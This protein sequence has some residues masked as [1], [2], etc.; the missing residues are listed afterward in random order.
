MLSG[1]VQ[2]M[3]S[4]SDIIIN[5]GS[6][7]YADE[8]ERINKLLKEQ[9]TI[10]A[11]SARKGGGQE[12]REKE[13]A[14]LKEQGKALDAN[15]EKDKSKK[16]GW[17]WYVVSLGGAAIYT[18]QVNKK[19]AQDKL[20]IEANTE[21]IKQAEQ[22]LLDFN[23]HGVTQNTIIDQIVQFFEDGKTSVDDFA[24]YMDNAIKDAIINGFKTTALGPAITKIQ[25]YIANAFAT[26]GKLDKTDKDVIN[27]MAQDAV[28]TSEP[29]WN[30]LTEAYPELFGKGAIAAGAKPANA[31]Q[32][33]TEDTGQAWLGMIRRQ[34]DEIITHTTIMNT[35]N[36]Y[37]YAIAQN[38][39]R[40]ADNTEYLRPGKIPSTTDRQFSDQP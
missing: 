21:A 36:G 3:Q 9:N 15:F 23:A 31:I 20:D 35:A 10:V 5:M 40:T 29:I 27:Q 2:A 28:K 19:I 17:G 18:A 16:P 24:S 7:K 30:A 33:L 39:L 1:A 11:D 8:L 37:L 32:A 26:K 12:A 34:T 13:L 14:L 4:I 38:T 22:D 25:E 6:Q